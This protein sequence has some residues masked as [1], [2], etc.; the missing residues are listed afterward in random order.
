MVSAA[1][2]KG[3]R[4]EELLP[5]IRAL[6]EHMSDRNLADAMSFITDRPAEILLNNVYE[7]AQL[8]A[9]DRRVLDCT[10]RLERHGFSAWCREP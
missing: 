7:A 2:P 9:T 10:R 6:Y 8:D 3:V 4:D 5:L 1:F